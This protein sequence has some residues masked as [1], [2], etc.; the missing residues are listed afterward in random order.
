MN[1]PP[2][3]QP[4]SNPPCGN[5]PLVGPPPAGRAG[6]DSG[7]AGL[8]ADR[9]AAVVT[10]CPGVAGLAAGP[11]ATYLPGR[12]VAGV[13]VRDT[14]PQGSVEVAVIARLGLPLTQIAA[15]VRAAVQPLAPGL[16]LD[17]RIDDI[18]LPQ[19]SPRA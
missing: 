13:A 5:P 15:Q 4:P 11:V 9:I 14:G 6:R 7:E 10:T 3:N 2:A 8:L 18:A 1:P 16:R 17:V 19:T 12:V